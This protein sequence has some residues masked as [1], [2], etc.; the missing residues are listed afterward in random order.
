VSAHKYQVYGIGNAIMDYQISISDSDFKKFNL[1]PGSMTLVEADVLNQMLTELPAGAEIK[2]S[3]GGSGANTIISLAQLGSSVAYGCIVGDDE[4]GVSYLNELKDLGVSTFNE[5]IHGGMT[6]RSL[7][8]ITPDAERTMSTCLGITSTYDVHH[9]SEQAIKESE[10]IYIEGYLFATAEG[11]RASLRAVSLAKE[12]GT[13]IAVTFSD[14]FIVEVF[15][16]ALNEVVKSSDLI[17]A[18]KNEA[19]KFTKT[20]DPIEAF[21]ELRALAGAGV[22]LTLS[23][24]GA[25]VGYGEE[26]SE[27]ESYPTKAVD[28]TG[29]GDMFAGGF[30]YGL[31]KGLSAR[32]SGKIACYLA[33]KVVSQYGARIN[34]D[35]KGILDKAQI[36]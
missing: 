27:V 2:R 30:M 33:G 18:N 24:K 13:K 16:D 21:R 12:Y 36:L 19:L 5:L 34:G 6:G 29:A 14:G 7:V 35:L 15:R 9:L 17:F 25:I 23:D 8:M 11:Q 32:D 10:W 1:E 4:V 26:V 3:S 22:A 31:L 28:D 20:S